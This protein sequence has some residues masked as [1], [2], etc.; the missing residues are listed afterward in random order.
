MAYALVSAGAV[1]PTLNPSF[2]AATTAGNLL[3]AWLF[4]NSSSATAPFTILSGAGWQCPPALQFGTAFVWA[5]IAYKADC[6]TGETAPQFGPA[7]V[8]SAFTKLGEFSGGSAASPADQ[9]GNG[10]SSGGG[11]QAAACSAPDTQAGDLIIYAAGWNG[12]TA[13]LTITP[14]MA[15]GAGNSITPGADTNSGTGTGVYYSFLWG[16]A[17]AAGAGGDTATSVLSGL[18]NGACGIASFSPAGGG[19]SS[20]PVMYSMRR[21]R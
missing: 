14:S 13:S 20:P 17:A 16:V 8:S 11:T 4:C 2:G 15:D 12:G 18:E 3:I 5:G 6:G 19:G 10:G 7:G 1:S 21:F 9:N